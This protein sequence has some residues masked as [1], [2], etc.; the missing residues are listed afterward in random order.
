MKPS[1]ECLIDL[2]SRS[3]DANPVSN[4]L[5]DREP[6]TTAVSLEVGL[7]TLRVPKVCSQGLVPWLDVPR[8]AGI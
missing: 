3:V 7:S 8:A 2:Y 6:V 5:I 4:W 1:Q